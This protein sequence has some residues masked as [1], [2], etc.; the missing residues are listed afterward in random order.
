MSVLQ[1]LHPGG[2]GRR[3]CK[4]NWNFC[5]PVNTGKKDFPAELA[6]NSEDDTALERDDIFVKNEDEDN[7]IDP[8][9]FFITA[10]YFSCCHQ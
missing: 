10:K 2:L 1:K 5:M 8:N 9:L 6:T 4:T 3:G 7:N